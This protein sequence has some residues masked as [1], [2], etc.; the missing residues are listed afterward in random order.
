MAGKG[1]TLQAIFMDH[2]TETRIEVAVF[3]LNGQ[4]IDG[5]IVGHDDFT[6]QMVSRGQAASIY[7]QYVSTISPKRAIDLRNAA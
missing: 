2:L 7:K 3:L 1:R 5:L 4:R 6:I